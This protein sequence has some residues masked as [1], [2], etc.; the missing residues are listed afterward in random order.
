MRSLR[1]WRRVLLAAAVMAVG[2]AL[3]LG[4]RLQSRGVSA[5]RSFLTMQYAP[6]IDQYDALE[7]TTRFVPEVGG[8][9][10]WRA[11]LRAQRAAARYWLGRYPELTAQGQPVSGAR[12]EAA[13]NPGHLLLVANAAYR[14]T[15][16]D[17]NEQT[18]PERFDSIARMYLDALEGDAELVDAAYNYEFVVRLRNQLVRDRTA[19]RRARPGDAGDDRAVTPSLHGS[20]GAAPPDADLKEFKVIVPQRPE[21]RSQ[22]PEAG[23]SGGKVRKG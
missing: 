6:P 2:L 18:P 13:G 7:R 12:G 17:L 15:A 22:Q 1:L 21:E 14:Q 19:R 23:V 5:Q 10:R 16:G 8:V 3:W 20:P 4:G 11:G 9:A